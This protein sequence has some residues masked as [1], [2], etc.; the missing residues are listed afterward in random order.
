MSITENQPRRQEANNHALIL[1]ECSCTTVATSHTEAD[2][3]AL[4]KCRQAQGVAREVK[5]QYCND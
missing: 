3:A 4:A 1:C 2:A 5:L